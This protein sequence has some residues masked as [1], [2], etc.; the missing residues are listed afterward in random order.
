[1]WLHI[2]QWF[3]KW[4]YWKIIVS[5]WLGN[6]YAP[7]AWISFKVSG[8]STWFLFFFFFENSFCYINEVIRASWNFFKTNKINIV[9]SIFVQFSFCYL[10]LLFQS[11]F[12][13]LSSFFLSIIG[14]DAFCLQLSLGSCCIPTLFSWEGLFFYWFLQSYCIFH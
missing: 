13:V 3:K 4:K 7:F 8:N 14:S 5:H 6:K 11:K 9:F 2:M 12:L 1:M 10:S